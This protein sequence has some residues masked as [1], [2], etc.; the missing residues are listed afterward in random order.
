MGYSFEAQDAD[1]NTYIIDVSA[2]TVSTPTLT[3][4]GSMQGWTTR[5]TRDGFH[6]NKV[7][8]GHYR[9]VYPT[10]MI[11]VATDDPQAQ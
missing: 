11:D 2:P 1:G 5:Q 6:V 8:Q 7:G 4:T 9:I 10:R 3:G